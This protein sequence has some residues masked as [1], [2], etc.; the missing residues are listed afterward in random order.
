MFSRVSAGAHYMSDVTIGFFF[1][2][3][4]ILIMGL[5]MFKIPA[6]TKFLQGVT[7]NGK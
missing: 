2:A 4:P 6:V 7:I 5:I 3:V 1:G